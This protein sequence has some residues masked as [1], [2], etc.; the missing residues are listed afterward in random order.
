MHASGF[1]FVVH[2]VRLLREAAAGVQK[3]DIVQAGA[4]FGRVRSCV[5]SKGEELEGTP[6]SAVSVLGLDS[7]PAA[8]DT[9]RVYE[10]ES[11]AREAAAVRFQPSCRGKHLSDYAENRVRKEN[12]SPDTM[13]GALSMSPRAQLLTACKGDDT[14]NAVTRMH[15]YTL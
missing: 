8:G 5:G 13:S 9:F 15:R 14:A 4:A 1:H 3:G 7:V 2:V 12:D 6:S 10:S 11:D